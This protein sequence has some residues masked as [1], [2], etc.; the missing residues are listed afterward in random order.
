M[1]SR[2]REGNNQRG[3]VPGS[4]IFQALVN[5]SADFPLSGRA[6][7]LVTVR[8]GSEYNKA[9][10]RDSELLFS[11]SVLSRNF[12]ASKNGRKVFCFVSAGS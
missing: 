3:Q 12:S 1:Q 8:S 5:T 11:F 7:T 9:K 6:G 4:L 10:L 2:K